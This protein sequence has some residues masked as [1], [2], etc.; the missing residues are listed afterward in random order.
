MPKS[1]WS[2]LDDDIPFRPIFLFLFLILFAN[3]IFFSIWPDKTQSDTAHPSHYASI[4]QREMVTHWMQQGNNEHAKPQ[5]HDSN[6]AIMVG[7]GASAHAS[8]GRKQQSMY[9][10]KFKQEG[11]SHVESA[12]FKTTWRSS[13]HECCSDLH[14]NW[15][16]LPN[17][18]CALGS[19]FRFHM[20]HQFFSLFVLFSEGS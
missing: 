5:D 18:R 3:G 12:R 19:Y 4:E 14:E 16:D 7:A 10:T 17:L 9:I 13:T 6:F 1:T 2:C 8:R 20:R 11:S 15:W